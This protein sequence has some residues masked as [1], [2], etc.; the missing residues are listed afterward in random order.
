MAYIR[1]FL[2]LPPPHKKLLARRDEVSPKS[3]NVG[4]NQKLTENMEK[5]LIWWLDR[6]VKNGSSPSHN[7]IREAAN[8]HLQLIH[9]NN[10][11]PSPI[12]GIKEPQQFI[13]RYL[14]LIMQDESRIT[15]TSTNEGDGMYVVLL[16]LLILKKS[17]R[18]S[19]KEISDPQDC[20]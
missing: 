7:H 16:K 17:Q 9:G 6:K 10:T 11:T 1:V 13:T 2:R 5:T 20:T 14:E 18:G 8:R 4:H 19:S 15:T 3:T 12:V